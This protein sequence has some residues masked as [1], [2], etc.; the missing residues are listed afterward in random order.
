MPG[1]GKV[2]RTF[3]GRGRQVMTGSTGLD[4]HEWG[5]TPFGTH[6]DDLKEGVSRCASTRRRPLTPSSGP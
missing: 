2:G 5:V 6:P 3:H 1:H 4:D